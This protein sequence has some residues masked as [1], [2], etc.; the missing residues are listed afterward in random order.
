VSGL[1]NGG[2]AGAATKKAGQH[3]DRL[4]AAAA[5]PPV[6]VDIEILPEAAG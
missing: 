4:A 1:A 5:A 3:C 2:D 6:A